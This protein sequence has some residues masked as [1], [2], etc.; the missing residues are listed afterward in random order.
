MDFLKKGDKV[1]LITD[2]HGDYGSNPVWNGKEGQV[3]GLVTNVDLDSDFCYQVRWDNGYCNSYKVGDLAIHGE[4][5]KTMTHRDLT[6]AANTC[7]GVTRDSLRIMAGGQILYGTSSTTAATQTTTEKKEQLEAISTAKRR[8][9]LLTT[10]ATAKKKETEQ[11]LKIETKTYVDGADAS[12][13]SQDQ[14]FDMIARAEKEIVRLEGI[15]SKPRALTAK[16]KGL[17]EG[18]G[19]LVKISDARK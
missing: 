5:P 2:D 6:T 13:L 10:V 12:K 14:I 16:I 17:H 11:M 7:L 4:T 19:G 3:S 18:I 1:R 15:T 8:F 9:D